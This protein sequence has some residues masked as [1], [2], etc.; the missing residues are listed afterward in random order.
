M[1]GTPIHKLRAGPR[2]VAG[3]RV[4]INSVPLSRYKTA[5]QGMVDK[6]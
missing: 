2:T 6:L 5:L 4:Q 3:E 1:T